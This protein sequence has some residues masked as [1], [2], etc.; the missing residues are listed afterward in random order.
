MPRARIFLLCWEIWSCFNEFFNHLHQV[1]VVYMHILIFVYY[2]HSITNLY[3]QII[4]SLPEWSRPY[5]LG[6]KQLIAPDIVL[7]SFWCKSCITWWR[8]PMETFSALLAI[9]A[10]NSPVPGGFPAQRPVTRSFDVFFDLRLNELLRKQSWGWGFET[11]SRTSWRHVNKN[12]V[13]V[14]CNLLRWT[15][16]DMRSCILAM[17]YGAYRLQCFHSYGHI[18]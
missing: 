15:I 8:H 18:T 11:P 5:T 7:N 14:L 10:G 3:T 16:T 17:I 9:C 1:F 6:V 12:C 4:L 2:F 13:P